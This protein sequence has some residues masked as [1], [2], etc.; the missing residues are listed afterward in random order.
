MFHEF[1][2]HLPLGI[3]PIAFSIGSFAVRWYGIMYLVGFLV[4]YG[5][6]KIRIV[7]GEHANVISH[8]SSEK[9]QVLNKK[10]DRLPITDGYALVFDYLLM[11][12][13]AAIAGGRIGYVLFYNPAYFFAHPLSI[14]SPFEQSGN[15]IGL[16]G[17]SY[18]GALLG[19]LLGSWIFLK[20]K[21]IDFFAWAD[22]V[23]P[24]ATAGYFFGRIGNFLNGELYGRVTNSPLGMYFSANPFQLRHPSQ[25]YE[26]F[27]EGLLLFVVLWKM[28]RK[29][30][31]VGCLFGI[32]LAGYGLL[33]FLMEQ[34]REPDVQLGLFWG[35]LT[36]GQILSLAMI[37]SGLYLIFSKDRK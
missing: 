16:Y 23:I 28:R 36:M 11:A 15:M 32:Y 26:A 8:Q 7:N 27:L 6:L 4:T 1:Y 12:F 21:K 31:S 18:H 29:R 22:F 14:I 35:F 33:R 34:F 19:I 24:A 37:A 20:K 9:K 5:L 13:F 17:M 2:Q 25:L 3:N 10:N 30:M